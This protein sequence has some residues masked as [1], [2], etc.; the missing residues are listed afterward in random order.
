MSRSAR[1]ILTVFLVALA[2]RLGCVFARPF[3]VTGERGGAAA[4]GYPDEREYHAI[5]HNVLSE[6]DLRDNRGRRASRAPG[7]PLFLASVYSIAGERPFVAKLAQAFVGAVM[8][9]AVMALARRFF[10]EPAGLFAGALAA[11]Y[12]FLIAYSALLLSETIFTLLLLVAVLA[13]DRAWRAT[14]AP[15]REGE[16]PASWRAKAATWRA[17]VEAGLFFGLAMLVRSSLLLFPFFCGAV[18]LAVARRRRWALGLAAAALGVTLALQ[19]PWAARNALV[20]GRFVPTTLQV[21]ESLFEACGPGADGGPRMDRIDW[22]AERGGK[23]LNEYDN[24]AFFRRKATDWI[25]T[26]PGAFVRLGFVKLARFWSPVPN[27]PGYA[28]G[29]NAAI[30]LLSFLPVMALAVVGAATTRASWRRLIL[31]L[32]PVLYYSGLHTVF[33]GSVRY[34]TPV[35]PFLIVFAGA[36]LARLARLLRRWQRM[37][38]TGDANGGT[39]P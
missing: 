32:T 13:L 31:L 18:W 9:I 39:R 8:C 11:V 4:L 29:W 19:A 5:A 37:R 35:M 20:F 24:N 2:L 17:A 30:S 3:E 7:Y 16:A 28:G 23:T 33:V 38:R 15:V 27:A 6:R 26:H 14:L 10:G 22:I 36:G 25:R 21:G 1:I 34:R 12:P